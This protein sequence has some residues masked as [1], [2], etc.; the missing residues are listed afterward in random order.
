MSVN[1][2]SAL[3]WLRAEKRL[4]REAIG[5]G[6]AVLGVCLG[7]QLIASA[8]D[9]RVYPNPEREIGWLPVQAVA[10]GPGAVPLPSECTV[11]HWH[12]E[13]FDLPQ[14]AVRL[15]SSRACV[16]QAFRYQ[17]N[18]VGLQFHLETTPAGVRTLVEHCR[19]DLVPGPFVQSEAEVLGA[20]DD[21]FQANHVL[22][23]GVL[24]WLVESARPR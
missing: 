19:G 21:R 4:V 3:P 1:D 13:T 8:L 11:L 9:S 24:D 17:R 20:P 7:A 5:S 12:G 16:N 15:A 10:G 6:V 23:A 18:V 22:M 2:E 14:G